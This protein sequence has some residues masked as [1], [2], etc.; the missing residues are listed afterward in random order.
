MERKVVVFD[1]GDTIMKD[2]PEYEGPMVY[3]PEVEIL[4][5]I[6]ESLKEI[7][8]KYTICIASNAGDSDKKLMG[9]ALERA[10][11]REYFEYLFTSKELGYNKPDERFFKEIAAR[12]GVQPSECIM[13]GNDYK[14]DIIPSKKIGMKTVLYTEEMEGNNSSADYIIKSMSG[15]T[16]IIDL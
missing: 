2:I 3:W 16:K 13:V 4:D 10:G 5:G 14:K 15:L 1:W 12:I 9:R 7:S 8:T 11:I 6:E